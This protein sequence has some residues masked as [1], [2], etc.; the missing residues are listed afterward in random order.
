MKSKGKATIV[1][2]SLLC[3]L[4]I[5]VV[6]TGVALGD[7]EEVPH[8]MKAY[9]N[10]HHPA[11]GY[12]PHEYIRERRDHSRAQV[13]RAY[14]KQIDDVRKEVRESVEKAREEVR[15]SVRESREEARHEVERAVEQQR[16]QVRKEAM[17]ATVRVQN[18]VQASVEQQRI[19]VARQ[20]EEA[21]QQVLRGT[22]DEVYTPRD[23]EEYLETEE[24]IEFDYCVKKRTYWVC[25]E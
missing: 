22:K 25:H 5:I 15:H 12:L 11:Q 14:Q 1:A 23:F 4:L 17:D 18:D 16:M 9:H 13:E 10:H 8:G 2:A 20:V 6:S 19:E 21:R 7:S 24:V 3:F